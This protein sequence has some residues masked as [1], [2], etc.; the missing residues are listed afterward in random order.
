MENNDAPVGRC[1]VNTRSDVIKHNGIVNSSLL[2]YRETI[3]ALTSENGGHRKRR[4]EED[5]AQRTSNDKDAGGNSQF[6]GRQPSTDF[7]I[8]DNLIRANAGHESCIAVK[9]PSFD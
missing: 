5:G 3:F 9:K 6:Y 8:I 2:N 7:W 1:A 4:L